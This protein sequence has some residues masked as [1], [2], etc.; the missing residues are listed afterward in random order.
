MSAKP[1]RTQPDRAELVLAKLNLSSLGLDPAPN[2][3]RTMSSQFACAHKVPFVTVFR[4][5]TTETTTKVLIVS[6]VGF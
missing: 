4:Q 1:N 5:E 2:F 6:V 3:M